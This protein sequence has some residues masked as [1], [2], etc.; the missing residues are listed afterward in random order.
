MA[1]RVTVSVRVKVISVRLQPKICHRSYVSLPPLHSACGKGIAGCVTASSP[2]VVKI[3]AN[4]VYYHLEHSFFERAHPY[5]C[6]HRAHA[7]TPQSN[8]HTLSRYMPVSLCSRSNVAIQAF[9]VLL[10]WI[11]SLLR[12]QHSPQQVASSRIKRKHNEL[13]FVCTT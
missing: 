5:I 12:W 2:T 4:Q 10:C 1:R 13:L 6:I 9:Y 8:K 11:T 7:L 3:A